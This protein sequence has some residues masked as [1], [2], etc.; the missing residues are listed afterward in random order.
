MYFQVLESA[1]N[2]LLYLPYKLRYETEIIERANSNAGK[3]DDCYCVP[4]KVS[5]MIK[6][7]N[8]KYC[9]SEQLTLGGLAFFC[10]GM[11]YNPDKKD[12]VKFV[13]DVFKDPDFNVKKLVSFGKELMEISKRRNVAAHASENLSADSFIES[14]DCVFN[15]TLTMELRNMLWRFLEFFK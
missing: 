6:R 11:D 15:K 13:R 9:M 5:G 3:V 12:L 8:G 10:L 1:L 4:A 14:K 2:E 7:K